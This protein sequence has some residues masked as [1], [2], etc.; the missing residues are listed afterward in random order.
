MAHRN[1]TAGGC[2]VMTA[3]ANAHYRAEKARNPRTTQ[4]QIE[5]RFGIPAGSLKRYRA[6]LRR[7][8]DVSRDWPA[9]TFA[10]K[11]NRRNH[12]APS[13]P[14]DADLRATNEEIRGIVRFLRAELEEVPCRTLPAVLA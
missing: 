4:R 8:P 3:T 13:Q 9:D 5:K 12:Q 11:I 1:P 7:L 6:E 2:R 14:T 10:F